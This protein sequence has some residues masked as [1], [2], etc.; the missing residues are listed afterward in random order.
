[1]SPA[2]R[3]KRAREEAEQQCHDWR[4]QRDEDEEE[5][6]ELDDEPEPIHTLQ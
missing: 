2:A 3:S 5:L 4:R 1:M 6:P